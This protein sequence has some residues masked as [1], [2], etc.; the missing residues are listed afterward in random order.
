MSENVIDPRELVKDLA[1]RIGIHQLYAIVR[2]IRGEETQ[3]EGCDINSD[4]LRTE[5]EELKSHIEYMSRQAEEM[6]GEIKALSFAVRCNGVS[7]NEVAY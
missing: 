5:N 7:G 3:G 1:D 6:R 2:E 4:C